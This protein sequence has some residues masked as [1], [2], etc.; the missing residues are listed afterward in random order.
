MAL[1]QVYFTLQ[2]INCKS[3]YTKEKSCFSYFH[4]AQFVL[5]SQTVQRY[6]SATV[7]VL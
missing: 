3:V 7:F 2:I 5:Q 4:I 6:S 1:K